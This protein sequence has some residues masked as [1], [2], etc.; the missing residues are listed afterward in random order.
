MSA[1]VTSEADFISV[2]SRKKLSQIGNYKLKRFNL[3][4][5]SETGKFSKAKDLPSVSGSPKKMHLL[6]LERVRE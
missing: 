6:P 5:Q 4:R 3:Q 1:D 2:V